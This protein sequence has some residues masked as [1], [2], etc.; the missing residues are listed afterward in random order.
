[1]GA[2]AGIYRPSATGV[3]G[4]SAAVLGTRT[5]PFQGLYNNFSAQ[6]YIHVPCAVT[7]TTTQ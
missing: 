7:F 3:E 5:G 6:V 4:E 2:V 1:M